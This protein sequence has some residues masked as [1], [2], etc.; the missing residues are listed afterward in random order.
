MRSLIDRLDRK[1]L[2]WKKTTSITSR[3]DLLKLPCWGRGRTW[4]HQFLHLFLHFRPLVLSHEIVWKLVIQKSFWKL[5]PFKTSEWWYYTYEVVWCKHTKLLYL[6]L[7][8][9]SL[10][11]YLCISQPIW[12]SPT[13]L[14]YWSWK[15]SYRSYMLSTCWQLFFLSA[16]VRSGDHW[17][18]VT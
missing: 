12:W 5:V 18:Q 2:G 8:Q 14:F 4:E 9:E 11:H 13:M 3:L 16:R 7:N 17:G 10:V 6:N 1:L 15:C